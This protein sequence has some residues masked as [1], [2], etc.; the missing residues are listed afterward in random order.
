MG[1]TAGGLAE[2]LGLSLGPAWLI[3]GTET[4]LKPTKP[5]DDAHNLTHTHTLLR[6]TAPHHMLNIDYDSY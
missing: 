6:D 4:K 5:D 1:V 2:K 3:K